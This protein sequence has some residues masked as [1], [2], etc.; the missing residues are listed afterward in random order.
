M[1]LRLDLFISLFSFKMKAFVSV[2]LWAAV[3]AVSHAWGKYTGDDFNG[4]SRRS[5]QEE[6][7]QCIGSGGKCYASDQCCPHFVCAA[8][9]DLFGENPEVPGF[10]V[11]E[12]DLHPCT[13]NTE[14]PSDSKCRGMGRNGAN[15]CVVNDEEAPKFAKPAS[16]SK[17]HKYNNFPAAQGM[18]GDRCESSTECAPATDSGDALCCQQV[19]R[20]RQ[21][22]RTICDRQT[23]IAICLP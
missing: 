6:D 12:K 15:Y 1:I 21:K 18:L 2:I 23:P 13:R 14:C 9:D 17:S 11:R 8:F 7:V 3:I 4:L 16:P 19:K 5:Y 20:Y 10:C 22:A